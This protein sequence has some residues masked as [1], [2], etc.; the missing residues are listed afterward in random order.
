MFI[1]KTRYAISCVVNFYKAGV[2]TRG[3]KIGGANPKTLEFT[4]T[5]PAL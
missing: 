1:Q 2:L 4:A 5:T 3:H